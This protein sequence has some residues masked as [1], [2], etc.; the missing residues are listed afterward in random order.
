MRLSIVVSGFF[1][2]ALIIV[3]RKVHEIATALAYQTVTIGSTT[4]QFVLHNSYI[5]AS[6]NAGSSDIMPL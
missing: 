4:P 2:S 3:I 6:A 5:F 1:G